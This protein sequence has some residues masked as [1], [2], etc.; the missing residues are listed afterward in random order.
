MGGRSRSGAKPEPLALTLAWK[1]HN[2]PLREEPSSPVESR[3]LRL[4]VYFEI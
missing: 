3:T 1:P 2:R 4:E